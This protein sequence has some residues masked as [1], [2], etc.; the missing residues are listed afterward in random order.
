M[1]AVLAGVAVFLVQD[2][3]GNLK[4]GKAIEYNEYKP[5]ITIP[6]EIVLKNWFVDKTG[7]PSAFY[8][9]IIISQIR[10]KNIGSSSLS[11]QTVKIIPTSEDKVDPGIISYQNYLAPGGDN[12][13][14]SAKIENGELFL[15]YPLLDNG[16]QHMFW[17]AYDQFTEPKFIA[18]GPNLKVEAW[19]K[20]IDAD[21]AD[22]DE[23]WWNWLF[24]IGQIA[25]AFLIGMGVDSWVT[26]RHLKKRGYDLLEIS[27]APEQND[28]QD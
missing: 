7:K 6:K 20:G 10:V 13:A 27:K 5:A 14:V 25:I 12:Q 9:K 21:E 28:K 23:Y 16:D 15:H 19:D 17:I 4:S 3:Y 8:N 2:F 26:Y 11:N 1:A 18:R 22:R 24:W